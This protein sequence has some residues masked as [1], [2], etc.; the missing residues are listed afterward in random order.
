MAAPG[1]VILDIVKQLD[2]QFDS[3]FIGSKL[4]QVGPAS[5]P[6]AA[7]ECG[8]VLMEAGL[9]NEAEA[10]YRAMERSFPRHPASFVGLAQVAMRAQELGGS[11]LTRWDGILASFDGA[12][13]AFWLSARALTLFEVGRREEAAAIHAALLSSFPHEAAP[14]AGLAQL[15]MRQRRWAQALDRSDELLSKFG[16]HAAANG[17]K[18]LRASALF[19]LGRAA[20]AEDIAKR[21]VETAPGLQNALLV[22]LDVYIH[23]RRPEAAW[24][25]FSA[26]P[27]RGLESVALVEKRFDMLIRLKRLDDARVIFDRRLKVANRPDTLASLFS[28]VPALYDKQDRRRMWTVLLE[29]VGGLLG[30]SPPSERGAWIVIQARI[31]LALRDTSAVVTTVRDLTECPNLAEEGDALRRIS[32]A[33]SDP[34]FPD[35]AKPKIFGIGLSRTGTTTSATALNVL[36]FPYPP[37]AESAYVRSAFRRRF[38]CVRCFYRY[39]RQCAV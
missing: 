11:L 15:A 10:L 3:G 23:S 25:A 4:L 28:F 24:Q 20:E 21:V 32:A 31:Q 17:W 16:D 7:I 5:T 39:S 14:Y 30:N 36:G 13:N 8:R 6:A 18:V 27:F 19:E 22:L 1:D 33:L 38:S 35:Y 37:L 12:R 34:E 2:G 29:R 26:S 9:A